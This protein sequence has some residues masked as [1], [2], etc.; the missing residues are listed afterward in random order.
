MNREPIIRVEKLRKVF[1][2]G[3]HEVTALHG[4]DFEVLAGGKVNIDL[5]GNGTFDDMSI[6][7]VGATDT[8]LTSTDFLVG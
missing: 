1:K 2:M 3:E 4:I 5:D 6:V 7:I 8:N